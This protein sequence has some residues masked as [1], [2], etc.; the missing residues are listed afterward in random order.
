MIESAWCWRKIMFLFLEVTGVLVIDQRAEVSTV[1]DIFLGMCNFTNLPATPSALEWKEWRRKSQK[2]NTE[3]C[4]QW[5]VLNRCPGSCASSWFQSI[6]LDAVCFLCTWWGL[7]WFFDT[8]VG[9][10]GTGTRV[11]CFTWHLY[12]TDWIKMCNTHKYM[13]LYTHI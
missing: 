4:P 12:E 5:I 3:E 11:V 1:G 7:G 10:C 6:W 8:I 13:Y 9:R 2:S